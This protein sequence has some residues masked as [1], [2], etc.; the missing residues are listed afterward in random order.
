LIS[1]KK[2]LKDIKNFKD[3]HKSLLDSAKSACIKLDAFCQNL[4]KKIREF[5]AAS[6]ARKAQKEADE[7][8]AA[9]TVLFEQQVAAAEAQKVENVV[10]IQIAAVQPRSQDQNYQVP[11]R[12]GILQDLQLL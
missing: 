3:S 8:L 1:L 7:R 11:N 2:Q 10:P 9:C 6:Q 4:Q 12:I 5:E